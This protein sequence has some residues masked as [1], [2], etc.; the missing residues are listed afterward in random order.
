MKILN[1]YINVWEAMGET[2]DK[3]ERRQGVESNMRMRGK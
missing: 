2:G 1:D 3:A